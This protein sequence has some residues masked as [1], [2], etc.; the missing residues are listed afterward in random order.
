M[1]GIE[2]IVNDPG[3]RPSSGEPVA[4]SRIQMPT[5]VKVA[6]RSLENGLLYAVQVDNNGMPIFS[7]GVYPVDNFPKGNSPYHLINLVRAEREG[8]P[9]LAATFE[10]KSGKTP[11][12]LGE[13]IPEGLDKAR[14]EY[15]TWHNP[16]YK[17]TLL[18]SV[19]ARQLVKE[20]WLNV[21]LSL[22]TYGNSSRA[23]TMEV[24]SL[25]ESLEFGKDGAFSETPAPRLFWA[26]PELRGLYNAINSGARIDPLKTAVALI[27]GFPSQKPLHI[28]QLV[29]YKSPTPI[30]R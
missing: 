18:T 12:G 3:W 20:G 1:V 9:G 19:Q 17:L 14:I 7:T 22:P 2:D 29:Q 26:S 5:Q 21:E 4:V 10:Y 25:G 30:Q 23:M 27:N 28:G 24:Y 8:V 16:I 11:K 6:V 15:T 13:A